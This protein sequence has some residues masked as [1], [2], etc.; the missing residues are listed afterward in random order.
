MR[1]AFLILTVGMATQLPARDV[2]DPVGSPQPSLRVE[3]DPRCP[4]EARKASVP[5]IS[6]GRPILFAPLA[7]IA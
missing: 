7:S 4:E 1:V 3:A 2:A 5:T 6:E